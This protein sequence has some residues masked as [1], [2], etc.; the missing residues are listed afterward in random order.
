M[1]KSRRTFQR[2]SFKEHQRQEASGQRKLYKAIEEYKKLAEAQAEVSKSETNI[3]P[4][5]A[6][7]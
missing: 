3:E 6:D 2:L 5:V 7:I 4:N 1:A